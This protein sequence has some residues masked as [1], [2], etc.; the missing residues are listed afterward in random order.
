[1]R[2]VRR[3]PFQ[4][5]RDGGIALALRT[6]SRRGAAVD[7]SRRHEALIYG[8]MMESSAAGGEGRLPRLDSLTGLRFIAAFAVILNHSAF[9]P[10]WRLVHMRSLEWLS[11]PGTLGV[12]FF[13]A[14]SGFVLTWSARRGDSARNFFKRRF[15]RVY[16]L[17]IVTW[18]VT[19][20]ALLAVGQ[21]VN[22]AGAILGVGLLQACTPSSSARL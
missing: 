12:P 4:E 3:G 15:A 21:T 17:H 22:P 16:P 10:D 18:M 1:M 9:S 7:R 2:I 5:Q 20:L 19:L 14:L 11:T 8:R 6:L 13:F